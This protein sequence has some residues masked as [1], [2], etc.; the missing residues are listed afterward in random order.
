MESKGHRGRTHLD[1]AGDQNAGVVNILHVVMVITIVALI[2][3]Y[4]VDKA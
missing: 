2:V 1:R 3:G 4:I